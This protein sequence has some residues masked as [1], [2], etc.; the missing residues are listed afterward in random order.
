M[1]QPSKFVKAVKEKHSIKTN[2][3]SQKTILC[4]V[5]RC[6]ELR[7]SMSFVADEQRKGMLFLLKNTTPRWE[8]DHA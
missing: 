3:V 7:Y 2:S 5:L 8:L 6:T 1:R 4:F